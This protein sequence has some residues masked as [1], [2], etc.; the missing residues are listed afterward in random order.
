MKSKR[1]FLLVFAG[2]LVA[3]SSGP[4]MP[5]FSTDRH[6]TGLPVVTLQSGMVYS[7]STAFIAEVDGQ[8]LLATV[9]DTWDQGNLGPSMVSAQLASI[10]LQ[11]F[12]EPRRSL[13]ESQHSE[14]RAGGRLLVF[15]LESQ[16]N[17]VASLPLAPTGR[18]RVGDWVY[19]LGCRSANGA[20]QV[21]SNAVRITR[22]EGDAV[23]AVPDLPNE[24]HAF[25]GAPVLTATG[26]LVAIYT[27]FRGG[28]DPALLMLPATE[29]TE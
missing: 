14:W 27:G 13:A 28:D 21:Q 8:N 18:P 23:E 2:L 6:L 12:A 5:R 3:C 1:L 19:L 20:C 7:A 10:Q 29:L 24:L 4:G 25:T 16:S 15:P 17:E 26:E 9:A 22:S 11:T